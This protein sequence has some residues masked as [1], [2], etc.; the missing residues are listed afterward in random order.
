MLTMKTVGREVDQSS[1]SKTAVVEFH[2]GI[3]MV[4]QRS[5]LLLIIKHLIF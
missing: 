3:L 1:F 2:A 5:V 4:K